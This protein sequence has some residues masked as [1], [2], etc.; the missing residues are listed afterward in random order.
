MDRERKISA[1]QLRALSKYGVLADFS[2]LEDAELN[3]VIK[4]SV[5]AK[6]AQDMTFANWCEQLLG[7][8]RRVPVA[9]F[10]SS[11][12]GQTL[13]NKLAVGREVAESLRARERQHNAALKAVQQTQAKPQIPL[14]SQTRQSPNERSF[15]IAA[16]LRD[17]YT[18]MTRPLHDIL[19]DIKEVEGEIFNYKGKS[20]RDYRTQLVQTIL[21]SLNHLDQLGFGCEVKLWDLP[22]L[23]PVAP[24]IVLYHSQQLEAG[25]FSEIDFVVKEIRAD[26]LEAA[27]EFF[28]LEQTLPDIDKRPRFACHVKV[29]TS[30]RPDLSDGELSH[31]SCFLYKLFE[32]LA[33]SG[34]GRPRGTLREQ[35]ILC[36]LLS[37]TAPCM[38]ARSERPKMQDLQDTFYREDTTRTSKSLL[39]DPNISAGRVVEYL[40]QFLS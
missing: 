34:D 28:F 26:V 3:R 6:A 7:K 4:G 10:E 16:D 13:L 18:G 40:L 36:L 14:E 30:R 22:P 38:P 15:G 21:S 9:R 35:I 31:L 37:H 27:S 19:R 12:A 11:I 33:R 32:A 20:N 8:G 24:P 1:A 17:W 23:D 5:P 25:D 29:A 2:K 39:D